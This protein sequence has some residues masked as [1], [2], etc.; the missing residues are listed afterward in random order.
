M[1]GVVSG[2]ERQCVE[3]VNRFY[4]T[5]GWTFAT[6][7]GYGG[8]LCYTA[9]ATLTKEPTRS[10]TYFSPGDVLELQNGGT[11]LVAV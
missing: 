2:E 6:W 5:K 3:F 10:I 11:V 9:P 8:Q 1:N 4:F 7:T